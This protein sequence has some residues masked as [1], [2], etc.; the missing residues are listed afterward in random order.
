MQHAH[1]RGIIHRDLKPANVLLMAGDVPKVTDFGLAKFG[2]SYPSGS[3]SIAIP[4]DFG[5]PSFVHPRIEDKASELGMSVEDYVIRREW[6]RNRTFLVQTE[7][8]ERRR[9]HVKRFLQ[10]AAR[11]VTCQPR[12]ADEV[13]ARLTKTG[14]IMG[15]PL[16]MAPEQA[17]GR[18]KEVGPAADV[19]S[20]GAVMYKLLT[21]QPPFAGSGSLA[22]VLHRIVD[23]TPTPPRRHRDS[24][25]PGLEAICMKCLEK[26]IPRRYRSMGELS[27]VLQ[28]FLDGR[29]TTALQTARD[30]DERIDPDRGLHD[31][32]TTRTWTPASATGRGSSGRRRWWRFW[33]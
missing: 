30:D 10:E 33:K 15:T 13:R 23:T 17:M 28:R 29:D 16:Y 19:Y 26:P 5:R 21:G 18:V 32:A 14:A 2:A 12:E 27:E 31:P 20:L 3:C 24:I 25:D 11:Q 9:D 22:D 8:Y 4:E 1:D 7:E 6:A